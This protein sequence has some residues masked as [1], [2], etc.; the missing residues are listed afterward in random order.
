MLDNC[1]ID[2]YNLG[3]MKLLC[4]NSIAFVEFKNKTIAK[5]VRKQKQVAKIQGRDLVVDF[6]G[7]THM[8][9]AAEAKDD[10]NSNTKGKLL[11]MQ[12]LL[13]T[14]VMLVKLFIYVFLF[15]IWTSVN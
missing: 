15:L 8:P 5:K 3:W 2:I 14:A 9:K 4:F 7:Q 11:D 1:L 6:V 10:D 13:S 12:N